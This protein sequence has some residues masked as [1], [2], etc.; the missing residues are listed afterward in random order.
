MPLQFFLLGLLVLTG[1]AA[2]AYRRL[3][4]NAASCEYCGSLLSAANEGSCAACGSEVCLAC[5]SEPQAR[6]PM[7]S[8]MRPASPLRYPVCPGCARGRFPSLPAEPQKETH[9]GVGRS[10][11]EA[12][13]GL[14]STTEGTRTPSS[15]HANSF[16]PA[17]QS[18]DMQSAHLGSTGGKHAENR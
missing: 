17:R 6:S 3:Q 7:L 12:A 18:E 1:A 10:L 2:G 4:R 15:A 13:V 14:Q 11:T 5:L 8:A 9:A 16:I